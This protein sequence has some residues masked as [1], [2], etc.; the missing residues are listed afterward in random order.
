MRNA[1][2]PRRR[3]GLTQQSFDSLLAALAPDRTVAGEKYETLRRRL[4]Q[5]F[6]WEA[7]PSP[8]DAADLSLDRVAKRLAGGEEIDNIE[9]Y[10]FGVARY[11][12]IEEKQDV[13]L[14]SIAIR[15]AV[16]EPAALEPEA[17]EPEPVQQCLEHCLAELPPESSSLLTAYYSGEKSARIQQR[18]VLAAGLGLEMNALRNR[19]LRLRERLEACIENCLRVSRRP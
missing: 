3:W 9:H 12:L 18:K 16:K 17:A 19:A 6:A 13:R 7:I 11:V 10:V 4:I 15:N 14:K 2:F 5:F 8:E 1:P